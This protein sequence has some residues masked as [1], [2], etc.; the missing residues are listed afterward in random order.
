MSL[1]VVCE[2]IQRALLHGN[3]SMLVSGRFGGRDAGTGAVAVVGF[4]TREWREPQQQVFEG[5]EDE[6]EDVDVCCSKGFI[7]QG[8]LRE[9]Q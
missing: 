6:D 3:G 2:V 4:C 8:R 1:L 7:A 5:S 9:R